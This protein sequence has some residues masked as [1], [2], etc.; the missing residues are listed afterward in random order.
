MVWY[1]IDLY[2][3]TM[4]EEEYLLF[5]FKEV[6][7]LKVGLIPNVFFMAVAFRNK[8]C[9][10]NK[11]SIGGM[12]LMNISTLFFIGAGTESAYDW[13]SIVISIILTSIIALLALILLI[14]NI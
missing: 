10:Y 9:Y 7:W 5:Y 8:L 3:R 2:A 13:Y 14:I 4:S 12:M 1:F 11:V 6:E